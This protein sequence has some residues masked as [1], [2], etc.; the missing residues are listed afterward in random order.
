MGYISGA[1]GTTSALLGMG[2]GVVDQALSAVGSVI[3]IQPTTINY[4]APDIDFDLPDPPSAFN[5]S[6]ITPAFDESVDLAAITM[7]PDIIIP[8]APEAIDMGSLFQGAAPS[9]S[10][11]D[12]Y[13]QAPTLSTPTLPS[14]PSVNLPSYETQTSNLTVPTITVPD[15]DANFT[16][17]D[18]GALV[19]PDVVGTFRELTPELMASLEAHA[20]S[21]MDQWCPEYAGA[22]NTL[23]RKIS[24]VMNGSTAITDAV[25]Q[26]IFDR[27]RSR[28]M[29][30]KYAMD[31]QAA[32]ALSRRGFSIP[33][34]ALQAAFDQA[35]AQYSKLVSMAASETAIRRA[36]LE[37]NHLQFAM[38]LSANMRMSM[39]QAVVQSQSN[40]IG[41]FGTAIEIA[42]SA[43]DIAV[44]VFNAEV[45]VY[46]AKADVYRTKAEVYR[47]K[48]EAA[49][50]D[51]EVFKATVEAER[52][53]VD[54][55]RNAIELYQAK[56]SAEESK[57][58]MYVAQLDGVRQIAE[59]ESNKIAVFEAKVRAFAA[60]VQAKEAEFGAYRAAI[61]ADSV[62]VDAYGRSIDAYRAQIEG[63]RAGVEAR[64]VNADIAT[65]GNKTLVDLFDSKVKM[66]MAQVEGSG[67]E[68]D[69]KRDAYLAAVELYRADI[70]RSIRG[71][72]ISLRSSEQNLQV[73][74]KQADIS[75]EINIATGRLMESANETAAQI[76]MHGASARAQM[77]SASLGQINLSYS[78]SL[79]L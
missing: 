75:S 60:R 8:D 57:I 53:K 26:Q 49:F 45:D 16:A 12:S 10:I 13:L 18:P 40:A 73:A 20:I 3:N 68:Y 24:E 62:R 33:P 76:S 47:I 72:E 5:A 39:V 71:A 35:Q 43:A 15:F 30:E 28:A 54:L 67:R 64:K 2:G 31:R 55:D 34:M 50:A 56:I 70:E 37:L 19:D 1:T 74:L 78:E 17:Q 66:Y 6:F 51:L 14:A 58:R 69:S 41:L 46:R 44:R 9:F 21:M 48:V 25:E 22:M 7:P 42:R 4:Q 63:L 32:D 23:E 77:V 52:L 79:Q 38:N 36:E 11:D 29:D 61:E 65:E 27:A 59:I